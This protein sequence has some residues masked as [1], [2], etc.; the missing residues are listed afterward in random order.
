[1]RLGNLPCSMVWL[2]LLWMFRNFGGFVCAPTSW[3][4]GA[5][6]E[7]RRREKAAA[8]ARF[9]TIFSLLHDGLPRQLGDPA[10]IC[11]ALLL[12][13]FLRDRGTEMLSALGVPDSGGQ[14][15]RIRVEQRHRG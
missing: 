3:G 9:R 10:S 7:W 8:C 15:A 12:H 1:M 4:A 6:R 14:R 2:L 5:E 11:A 13:P